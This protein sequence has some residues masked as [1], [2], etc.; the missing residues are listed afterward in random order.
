MTAGRILA[1][2]YPPLLQKLVE[3][4]DGRGGNLP[5]KLGACFVG[6]EVTRPFSTP[7]KPRN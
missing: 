4:R 1:L 5:E 7:P 6:A 3:E 2:L